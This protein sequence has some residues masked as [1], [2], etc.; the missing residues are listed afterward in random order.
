MYLIETWDHYCDHDNWS[1][2]GLVPSVKEFMDQMPIG[3]SMA[4]RLHRADASANTV[5]AISIANDL[6]GD[7]DWNCISEKAWQDGGRQA[8]EDAYKRWVELMATLGLNHYDPHRWPC[9][10]CDSK[11]RVP[12]SI[13]T[14]CY[15]CKHQRSKRDEGSTP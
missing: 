6:C 14:T 5:A 2:A 1:P 12:P 11:L 8:H 3:G 15:S 10:K 7:E 13:E 4:I 9:A